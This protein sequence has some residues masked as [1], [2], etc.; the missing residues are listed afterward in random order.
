MKT[1]REKTVRIEEQHPFGIN[2]HWSDS[3]GVRCSSHTVAI[4]RDRS[5]AERR[6]FK[7]HQHVLATE[8]GE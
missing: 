4:G 8:D 6:F 1:K 7:Q 5:D 2:Y 3:G